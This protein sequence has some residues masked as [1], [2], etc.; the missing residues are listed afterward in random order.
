MS[1]PSEEVLFYARCQLEGML[2]ENADRAAKDYSQAYP[3][4][5]FLRLAEETR[6]AFRAASQLDS[7][8]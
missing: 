7:N 3:E 4:A 8:P 6:A 1:K 2:A 5:S